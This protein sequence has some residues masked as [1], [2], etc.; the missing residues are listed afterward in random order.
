MFVVIGF[1]S[2]I[3]ITITIIWGKNKNIIITIT[4]SNRNSNY[5]SFFL[6]LIAITYLCDRSKPSYFTQIPAYLDWVETAFEFLASGR[7]Q[8]SYSHGVRSMSN[9]LL[10]VVNFFFYYLFI[11]LFWHRQ[12]QL[13]KILDIWGR[14]RLF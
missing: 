2:F 9:S 8:P 12:M 11:C 7:V 5:N 14:K 6:L 4:I 1:L 13:C 10:V 3:I